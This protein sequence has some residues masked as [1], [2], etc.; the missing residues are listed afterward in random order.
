M[1]DLDDWPHVVVKAQVPHAPVKLGILEIE[2]VILVC[3]LRSDRPNAVAPR[4]QPAD[5]TRDI[6][7]LDPEQY[8]PP[9]VE[10]QQ[11]THVRWRWRK[12]GDRAPIETHARGLAIRLD[13]NAGMVMLRT[14][15]I[16]IQIDVEPGS[17]V[18]IRLHPHTQLVEHQLLTAGVVESGRHYPP[19][20]PA[21]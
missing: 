3:V 14:Q 5:V 20:F 21:R 7:D 11:A 16:E 18:T 10:F 8:A 13:E 12:P 2:Q 19:T 9:V 6:G 1:V 4:D 17:M 15:V